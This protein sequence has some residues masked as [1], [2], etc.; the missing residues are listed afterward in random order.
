MSFTKIKLTKGKGFESCRPGQSPKRKVTE[1]DPT[2]VHPDFINALQKLAIHLVVLYGYISFKKV[3]DIK[4]P[5]EELTE[6]VTVTGYNIQGG[7]EDP[8]IMIT[9]YRQNIF[10]TFPMLGPYIRTEGEEAKKYAFTADILEKVKLIDSEA[11]QFL[12]GEK[13]GQAKQKN[14]E[15]PTPEETP[16]NQ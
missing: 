3:K 8:R 2:P 16:E 7:D 6:G 12:S 9:G 5:E 13:I 4:S 10:G 1:D 11:E 14:L 15:F